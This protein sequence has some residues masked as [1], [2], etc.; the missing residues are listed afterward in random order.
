MSRETEN[1]ILLLVGISTAMIAVTGAYT[2]YVKPSLLPWLVASAALL[3]VLALVAIVRDIRDRSSE[4]HYDGHEHE[5]DHRH[6]PGVAWLLAVPIA[7]LAFVVPPPI[8]PQAAGPSVAEISPQVLR[9]AFPPL[10]DERAPTLS[11]PEILVRVAQDS[12]NTLDDRLVTVTGFTL[13]QNGRTDLA[14]VVIM[15]CA[16]D[17]RLA[18]I[19]LSGPAALQIAAY[20]EDTWVRVEG[21]IPAGQSDPSGRTVPIFNAVSQSRTDPPPNPYAY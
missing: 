17:A 3:V 5:H 2:R 19:R 18:R 12:A 14:R 6:R 8:S 15:C 16:A 9:R 1:A 13:K 4:A 21:K 7:L 11:L 10:P 20:P